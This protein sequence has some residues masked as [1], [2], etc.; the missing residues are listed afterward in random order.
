VTPLPI[1][2]WLAANPLDVVEMAS[3]RSAQT[4]TQD[5]SFDEHLREQVQPANPQR[6]DE[7]VE[8]PSAANG[9]PEAND[10]P[11]TQDRAAAPPESKEHE[12]GDTPA[13][14][15][16]DVAATEGANA[17]S[18][19]NERGG[20]EPRVVAETEAD[21]AL[22]GPLEND[23]TKPAGDDAVDGAEKTVE[24]L[25]PEDRTET[26]QAPFVTTKAGTKPAGAEPQGDGVVKPKAAT[27]PPDNA[28]SSIGKATRSSALSSGSDAAEPAGD[29]S[30]PSV[31]PGLIAS[32][33]REQAGLLPHVSGSGDVVATTKQ[34]DGHRALPET[35][36]PTAESKSHPQASP[37]AANS[38]QVV[39]AS[40]DRR[41]G[42]GPEKHDRKTGGLADPASNRIRR[43]FQRTDAAVTGQSR[44]ESTADAGAGTGAA[45]AAADDAVDLQSGATAN[46]STTTNGGALEA[47][48]G[49]TPAQVLARGNDR[50]TSA[51]RLS[52]AQQTRLVQRVARAFRAAQDR[53]GDVRIRLSP[54]ELGSLKIE[55]RVDAGVMTAR[56][57]A[58]TH[59][60]RNALL[61]NLPALRE[62]LAEH[63]VRVEQF[64]VDVPDRR[65]GHLSN[66]P[67][68]Q[69][70]GSRQSFK[71]H[72]GTTLGPEEEP[73][74]ERPAEYLGP[75]RDDGINVMI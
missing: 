55:L 39:T 54:P 5:A 14:D 51:D 10:A 59:V 33:E 4:T 30:R 12:R 75:S 41:Q 23:A 18:D 50:T 8:S 36:S 19:Q 53:G 44:A 48:V 65:G 72:A 16:S 68:R 7:S 71:G 62:R 1:D 31:D 74:T 35:E 52:G 46:A 40:A 47:N 13:A 42:V 73:S 25:P 45:G 27:D 6:A 63:N 64:D 70:A 28:T 38:D 20:D 17:A 56:L 61:D 2:R 49:R 29:A 37:D 22:E 9:D 11:S 66:T 21:A 34:N 57:E 69:S 60:A 24:E 32:P 26:P 15:D 58:E 43:P 3:S 67:D